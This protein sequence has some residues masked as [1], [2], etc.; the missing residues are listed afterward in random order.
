MLLEDVEVKSKG[1]RSGTFMAALPVRGGNIAISGEDPSS[2][3]WVDVIRRAQ[4]LDCRSP[5]SSS[6]AN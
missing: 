1:D 5:V 3:R 2:V 6:P 4:W